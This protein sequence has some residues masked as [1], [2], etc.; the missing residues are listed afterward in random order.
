MALVFVRYSING[1][2]GSGRII[3]TNNIESIFK[4][5][6]RVEPKFKMFLMNGEVIDF[7]QLYYNGNFVS[8]HTMEQLYKLLSK[9]DSGII[10]NGGET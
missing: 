1:Q 7:N 4:L 8:I 5:G 6:D 2:H 3:N 9:L 10:Q